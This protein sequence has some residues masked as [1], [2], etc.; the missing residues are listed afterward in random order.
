MKT[1]MWKKAEAAMAMTVASRSRRVF[2]VSGL[3]VPLLMRD[4][5]PR[6][7]LTLYSSE[8]RD[9]SEWD[10]RLLT[11]LANHTAIAI[12]DAETLG[13]GDVFQ[14]DAAKRGLKHKHSFYKFV[15]IFGIQT[16]WDTVNSTQVFKK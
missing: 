14:V 13:L 2:W 10:Q 7:A 4:G 8:P 3:I 5:T 15:G 16:D 12:Q 6:G 1:K 9:F 11:W